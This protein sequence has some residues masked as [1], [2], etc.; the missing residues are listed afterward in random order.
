LS[1]RNMLLSSALRPA[2]DSDYSHG[3]TP[4]VK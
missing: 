3:R 2:T 1:P 4:L